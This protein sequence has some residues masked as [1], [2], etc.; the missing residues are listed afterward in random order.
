MFLK[1]DS[2]SFFCEIEHKQPFLDIFYL[3]IL[4]NL[5]RDLRISLPVG[6]VFSDHIPYNDGRFSGSSVDC[7]PCCER[8][9]VRT[10]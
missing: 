9:F 10:E 5:K 2:I 3:W 8:C 4:S 7:G 6:L 1:I